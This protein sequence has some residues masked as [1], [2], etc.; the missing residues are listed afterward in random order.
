M[1]SLASDAKQSA[2][3]QELSFAFLVSQM[4]QLT[5]AI[6]EL[7]PENHYPEEARVVVTP[8][9]PSPT[10]EPR[11]GP[12]ERYAG[13]PDGF[14]PFLTNCSI[15]FS[16]RAVRTAGTRAPFLPIWPRQ[17]HLLLTTTLPWPLTFPSDSD[18]PKRETTDI[19]TSTLT[20]HSCGA[21]P[22]SVRPETAPMRVLLSAP[23]PRKTTTAGGKAGTGGVVA[24]A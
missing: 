24:L 7:A 19:L 20:H 12:P 21:A 23:I 16:V 11:I 2:A 18:P 3:T 9:A 15:Y 4:Q 14:N 10:S 6:T 22:R 1:A 13:D 17:L 5:A 8:P